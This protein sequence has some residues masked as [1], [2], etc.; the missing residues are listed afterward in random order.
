VGWIQRAED[1]EVL[2][3]GSKTKRVIKKINHD[4]NAERE[5]SG[6]WVLKRI[7]DLGF[8]KPHME[9]G[10]PERLTVIIPNNSSKFG[11]E[12]FPRISRPCH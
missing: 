10:T 2:A 3:E 11:T 12:K 8:Y 4:G 7:C 1:H 6:S 9:V 5:H